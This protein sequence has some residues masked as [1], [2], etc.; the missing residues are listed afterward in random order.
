MS[1]KSFAFPLIRQTQATNITI[2]SAAGYS[3]ARAFQ[4]DSLSNYANFSTVFQEYRIVKLVYHVIPT[5]TQ[6][7]QTT[8]SGTFCLD[9]YMATDPV[10]VTGTPTLQQ[11]TSLNTCKSIQWPR[12]GSISVPP[13]VQV[14]VIPD[15]VL[16]RKSPWVPTESNNVEHGYLYVYIPAVSTVANLTAQI[17]TTVWIR[18]RG[19]Q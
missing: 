3:N 19:I 4:I 12:R 16:T 2:T 18:F 13:K 9:Y 5:V 14:P 7:L 8:T 1:T 17:R 10:P 15:G 6:T 11:V